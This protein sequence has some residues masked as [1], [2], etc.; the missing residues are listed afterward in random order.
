MKLAK[1]IVVNRNVLDWVR[2]NRAMAG[3]VAG[4]L[5]VGVGSGYWLSR[6][7]GSSDGKPEQAIEWHEVQAVPTRTPDVEDNEWQNRANEMD[8][9]ENKAEARAKGNELENEG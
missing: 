6:G 1:I 7:P 2:T 3:V 8:A 4:A 9:A 5:V